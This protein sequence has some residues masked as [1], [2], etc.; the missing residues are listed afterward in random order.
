MIEIHAAETRGRWYGL[1]SCAEELVATAAAGTRDA[2]VYAVSRLVPKGAAHRVAEHP[3]PYA[4]ELLGMLADLESGNESRKRFALSAQHV[5]EGLARILTVAAAIPLGYVTS[6]GQIAKAAGTEARAVGRV[7]ATNPLYPI[8]P[9][10][11]VVGTD[12]ALVGYGGR[13]SPSALAAKLARLRS[14]AR[15]YAAER[16]VAVS[17]GTLRVYPVERVV[18]SAERDAVEAARQGRLFPETE[19]A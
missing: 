8:V 19:D 12:F 17:G 9:C 10:H 14:E 4:T 2:V 5:P 16:E 15:G 1:A 6:Y 11:R 7:M 3:V 18:E 13:R